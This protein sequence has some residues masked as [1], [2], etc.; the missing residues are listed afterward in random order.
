MVFFCRNMDKLKV[1]E[2]N[3]GDPLIDGHVGL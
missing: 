1:E 2:K 3:G